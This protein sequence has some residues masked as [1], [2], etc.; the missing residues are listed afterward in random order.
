MA[1]ALQGLRPRQARPL[2]AI[3]GP[4]AGP[5]S[6]SRLL[7]DVY[8]EVTSLW[9]EVPGRYKNYVDNPKPN[10]YQ[11]IHTTVVGAVGEPPRAQSMEIQVRSRQMHVHAEGGA[12]AHGL[13]KG[14]LASAPK[15][16]LV[17][18]KAL[19]VSLEG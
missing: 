14:G 18:V 19:G 1:A 7:Q 5:D 13:Y 6:E 9:D 2:A 17:D 8:R 16:V 15:E 11:S 3:D 4:G 10:G 12:A